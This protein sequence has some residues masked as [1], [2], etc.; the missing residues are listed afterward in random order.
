MLNPIRNIIVP[1]DFTENSELAA[2]TAVA[3]AAPDAATIHL[4]HVIR[5]P[6]L[7][8]TYDLNVPES[9]WEALRR[10]TDQQMED[11]RLRL[12]KMGASDVR[13]LVG[14]SLQPAEAIAKA[15]SD[16]DA[17]LVVMETHGE[18]ALRHAMLGSVAERTI[19]TCPIPVLAV[20]GFGVQRTPVQ[21]ILF[22]TDFS[23]DSQH[24]LTLMCS[25]A[26]RFGVH[27][28]VL[29]VVDTA[30]AYLRITSPEVDHYEKETQRMAGE[31]LDAVGRQLEGH[32]FT[33]ET[34]LRSGSTV[35]AIVDEAERRSSK[36]I[37]MGTHGHTG[38]AHTALGSVAERTLRLATCSVLTTRRIQNEVLAT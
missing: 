4:L 29:H 24:A 15:A 10:D 13:E 36:L 16:Y 12:S 27:V 11:L 28:D 2:R 20:K 30:P 9:I 35:D 14:E 34:H 26:E 5:L 23:P 38:F 1:T 31:H 6:I 32:G 7:H 19:R 33:V 22:A 3:L 25:F 18:Q 37:V 8:T 21:K 17:D